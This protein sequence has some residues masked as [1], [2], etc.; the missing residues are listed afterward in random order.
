VGNKY[1]GAD[2]KGISNYL[3]DF[4]QRWSKEQNFKTMRRLNSSY[5][6]LF[7]GV[8]RSI[9]S[10]ANALSRSSAK[11]VVGKI[12]V[13]IN[14]HLLKV[15][16]QFYRHGYFRHSEYFEELNDQMSWSFTF[17]EQISGKEI[18]RFVVTFAIMDAYP[19]VVRFRAKIGDIPVL[20]VPLARGLSGLNMLAKALQGVLK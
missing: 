7:S 1:S 4:L 6:G 10:M 8:R 20:E 9:L 5:S 3:Q 12:G 15:V 2:G 18:D 11:N 13:F 19:E 14:N 17:V 16:H